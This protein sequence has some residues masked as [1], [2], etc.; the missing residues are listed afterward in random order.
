MCTLNFVHFDFFQDHENNPVTTYNMIATVGNTVFNYKQTVKSIEL[1]EGLSLNDDIYPCNSENSKF[2][3]PDHDHIIKGDLHLI[4]MQKLR[5]Q[6][7]KGSSY[8]EPQS[9]NYSRCKKDIDQ[10]IKESAGS[11]TLNIN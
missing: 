7:N 9:L 3:H 5:K 1:D 8:R 2:C 4:N 11:L 6:Y 10:T